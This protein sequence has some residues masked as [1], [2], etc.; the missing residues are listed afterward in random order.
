MGSWSS[1]TTCR[2]PTRWR[3]L[4]SSMRP[5]DFCTSSGRLSCSTYQWSDGCSTLPA[6]SRCSERA[7]T[8]ALQTR[9]PVIPVAQWGP[10]ELLAPYGRVPRLWRRPVLRVWAGEPL[11]LSAADPPD[12]PALTASIMAEVTALLVQI[13]HAPPTSVLDPRA[14]DL[15][16]TGNQERISSAPVI[17]LVSGRASPLG[18]R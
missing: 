9:C 16:R 3:S 18:A 2:M 12:F 7:S 11:A 6:R 14:S 17:T 8:L 15:P 5:A 10:Q 4:T 13:R 1:P